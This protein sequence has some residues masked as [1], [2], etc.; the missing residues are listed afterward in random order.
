MIKFK[1]QHILSLKLKKIKINF[2][3]DLKEELPK[4]KSKR[5]MEKML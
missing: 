2:C 4:A 1:C 5:L 3:K